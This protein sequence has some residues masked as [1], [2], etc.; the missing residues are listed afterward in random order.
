MKFILLIAILVISFLL[1]FYTCFSRGS[2][3]QT[4]RS[5]S[6]ELKGRGAAQ[7]SKKKPGLLIL[8]D[9]L[10]ARG[11]WRNLQKKYGTIN[12]GKG[13]ALTSEVFE[14]S[15]L[16]ANKNFKVRAIAILVGTNDIGRQFAIPEILDDYKKLLNEVSEYSEKIFIVSIPL[17]E[18]PGDFDRRPSIAV[19]NRNLKGLEGE[20]VKFIDW[21][22]ILSPDSDALALEWATD[23]LHLKA[24]AYSLLSK[25]ILKQL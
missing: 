8:G 10:A 3:Y 21:N 23:A 5:V 6:D 7:Y 25:E 16:S 13:G 19:L 12:C 15:N 22:Q 14:D 20:A 4:A 1:G 18:G 17:L 9:S 2:I 24:K 11:D